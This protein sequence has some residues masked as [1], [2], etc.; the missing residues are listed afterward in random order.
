[1][2]LLQQK[3][4]KKHM[5]KEIKKHPECIDAQEMYFTD[6]EFSLLLWHE[7]RKE[8]VLHGEYYDVIQIKTVKGGKRIKCVK[9]RAELELVTRY[10]QSGKGKP[11]PF[12]QLLKISW[13]KCVMEPQEPLPTVQLFASSV[14][15]KQRF[16]YMF[17][18]KEF[19][20]NTASPPPNFV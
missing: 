8:F 7:G 17:A 18:V 15:E 5:M 1:M 11:N 3:R 6:S 16:H 10:V 13:M 20:L 12:Q 4:W 2:F 14:Q 9:D 19:T